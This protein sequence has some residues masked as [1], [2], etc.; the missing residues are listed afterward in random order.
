VDQFLIGDL[1]NKRNSPAKFNG[2]ILEIMAFRPHTTQIIEQKSG[3]IFALGAARREEAF[4]SMRD[5]KT[6]Q[7]D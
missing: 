5:T 6:F 4:Q 3:R 2:S 1:E 7:I